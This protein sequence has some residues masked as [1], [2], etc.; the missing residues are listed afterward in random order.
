[1]PENKENNKDQQV[2]AQQTEP[3]V[4]KN[5]QNLYLLKK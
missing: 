1:M 5:L 2:E 3:V 4:E